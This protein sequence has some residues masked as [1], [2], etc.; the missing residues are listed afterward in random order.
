MQEAGELPGPS[1]LLDQMPAID[2]CFRFDSIQEIY[3]A[4]GR[5]DDAWSKETLDTLNK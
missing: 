2:E 3:A 5:R 4:L 1:G